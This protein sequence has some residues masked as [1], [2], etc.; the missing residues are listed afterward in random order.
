MVIKKASGI[1]T[2]NIFKDHVIVVKLE[3]IVNIYCNL[4]YIYSFEYLEVFSIFM[5]KFS[6]HLNS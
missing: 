3:Y 4:N 2:K 1:Y 5:L 6:T